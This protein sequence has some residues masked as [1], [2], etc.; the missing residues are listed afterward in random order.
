MVLE[1]DFTWA[2][3]GST[4][5]ERPCSWNAFLESST[6]L[7]R[8]S[9]FA[10]CVRSGASQHRPHEGRV[11]DKQ[12][13]DTRLRNK[14]LILELPRQLALGPL[15]RAET[16]FSRRHPEWPRAKEGENAKNVFG[17]VV[18]HNHSRR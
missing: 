8:R 17:E 16:E 1:R 2:F 12:E 4:H 6:L 9:P 5:R 7:N 11:T 10:S 18:I 14:H 15:R 13:T 3:R